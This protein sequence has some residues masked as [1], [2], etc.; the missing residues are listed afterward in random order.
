[1]KAK[2]DLRPDAEPER[3]DCFIAFGI[4]ACSPDRA[5]HDGVVSA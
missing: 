3:S 4:A 5:P 2:P 1:M